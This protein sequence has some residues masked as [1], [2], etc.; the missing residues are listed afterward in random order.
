[1]CNN[2]QKLEPLS[3]YFGRDSFL[4]C[5][6]FV[7]ESDLKR[8]KEFA[9]QEKSWECRLPVSADDESMRIYYPISIPVWGFVHQDHLQ[10][11]FHYNFVFHAVDG[12]IL[13]ATVY[14]VKDKFTILQKNSIFGIHGP[15]KWFNGLTFVDY[16]FSI[17]EGLEEFWADLD[18]WVILL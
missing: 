16:N 11:E 15:V 4:H 8:F 3:F 18:V 17:V 10:N 1:M 9:N 13:G 6:V 2:D 12:L 14:P 7:K 5:G